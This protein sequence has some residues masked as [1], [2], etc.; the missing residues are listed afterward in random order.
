MT[1]IPDKNCVWQITPIVDKQ[2]KIH[3]PSTN[4]C[5]NV[6]G[7]KIKDNKDIITY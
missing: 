4:Q 7:G 2:V 3:I 1:R 5:W 6:A